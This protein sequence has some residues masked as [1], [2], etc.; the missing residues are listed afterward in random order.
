MENA[1]YVGLSQQMVLQRQMEILANNI[2]NVNTTGFKGERPLFEDYVMAAGPRTPVSYVL[3]RGTMRDL[4]PG[5][6][7]ATGAPLD[8]AIEGDGFLSVQTANG[9]RYTRNGHLSLDADGRLVTSAG[10][11]VLDDGGGEITLEEGAGAPTIA[12]D[13]T[14]SQGTNRIG[15]LGVVRFA[16]AQALEGAGDGL[17]AAAPGQAAEPAPEARVAQGMLEQSN[18]QPVVEITRMVA[19]QRRY[20]TMQSLLQNDADL[21]RSAIQRLGRVTPA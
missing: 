12:P 3:D 6:F 8:L 9:P 14:L 19:L 5:A 13:G 7:S 2:A 17:F 20:Q 15:R 18:V 16:D 10:Q 4:A 11:A 1:L 21:Q